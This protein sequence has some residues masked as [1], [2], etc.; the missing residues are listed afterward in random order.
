MAILQ[1]IFRIDLLVLLYVGC[2][3]S[4]NNVSKPRQSGTQRTSKMKTTTQ[5]TTH[6]G[7]GRPSKEIQFG[8]C[9]GFRVSRSY[10]AIHMLPQVRFPLRVTDGDAGDYNWGCQPQPPSVEYVKR[11]LLNMF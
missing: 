7:F 3:E 1:Q 10:P 4:N 9:L 2:R 6:S 5:V 8:L 11:N